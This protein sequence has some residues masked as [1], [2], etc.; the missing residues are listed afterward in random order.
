MN[1]EGSEGS[2]AVEADHA[3]VEVLYVCLWL[4]PP[5]SSKAFYSRTL[6]VGLEE[7]D[8]S[9]EVKCFDYSA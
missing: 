4:G 7:A 5:G 2:V 3:V 1:R 8:G 9:D 6:P